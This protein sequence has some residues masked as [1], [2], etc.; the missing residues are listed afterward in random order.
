MINAAPPR[1][2][3]II[4]HLIVPSMAPRN[5]WKFL[6]NPDNALSIVSVAE[7]II[8]EAESVRL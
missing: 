6:P 7:D 3:G 5:A 8:Y 2:L 4:T 1:K